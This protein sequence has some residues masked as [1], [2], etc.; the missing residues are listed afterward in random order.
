MHPATI[1]T[2]AQAHLADLHRHARGAALVR[3]ARPPRAPGLRATLTGWARRP[4]PEP[5]SVAD[6][7][8]GGGEQSWGIGFTR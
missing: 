6:D 8:L 1:W 5:E 4:R 3:A 2:L 7:L